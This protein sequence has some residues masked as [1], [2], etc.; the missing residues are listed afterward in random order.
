[1]N[2]LPKGNDTTKFYI[3]LLVSSIA[4]T[5]YTR[6]KN[7]AGIFFKLRLITNS[8]LIHRHMFQSNNTHEKSTAPKQRK[9]EKYTKTE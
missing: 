4:F 6:Y 3:Q 9:E 8:L 2:F 7:S 5:N 1:M